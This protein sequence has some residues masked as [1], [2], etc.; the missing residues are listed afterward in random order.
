MFNINIIDTITA[1]YGTA[2]NILTPEKTGYTFNGWS[3]IIP[4]TM[5][6]GDMTINAN[7]TINH[8]TMT[9]VVDG[10]SYSVITQNY[11]TEFT[12]PNAPDKTGYTFKGWDK[13]IPSTIPAG[14]LTFVALYDPNQYVIT[15]I[16][17]GQ[18]YQEITQDYESS[19]NLPVPTKTGYRFTGW[20]SQAPTTMPA[21]NLTLTAVFAINQYTITYVLNNG[22][23]NIVDTYDY[24]TAIIAP[25]SPEKRGY[26]FTGWS[27]EI[28]AKIGAENIT[29]NANYEIVT[30]TISYDLDGGDV[31]EENPTTYTVE[32]D[33]ITF[34]NPT[35]EGYIFVGWV[36]NENDNPVKDYTIEKGSTGNKTLTAV[37]TTKS[38]NK[39]PIYV[40]SALAGTVLVTGSIAV[41]MA[42]ARSRKRR[43]DII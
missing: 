30:Y 37:W 38:D 4:T 31:D 28:P 15:I 18:V 7:F 41:G 21:E 29:V 16:V 5:P 13:I 43:K 40:G 39:M 27:E 10:H 1:D 9:F 2:L 42:I 24:D 17:D 26:T 25:A 32:S 22:Q 14:D 36:E 6:A 12:A 33:N 19:L 35:K 3:E 34:I 23:E 20:D 8:Y 11:N